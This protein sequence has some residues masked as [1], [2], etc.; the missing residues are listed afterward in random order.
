MRIYEPSVKLHTTQ[1]LLYSFAMGNWTSTEALPQSLYAQGDV[2][3]L[4]QRLR[5]RPV[6]RGEAVEGIG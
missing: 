1:P 3:A 6:A 4:R 2:K 5:R